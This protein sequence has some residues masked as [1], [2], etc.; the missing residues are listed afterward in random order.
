L[1][2]IQDAAIAYYNAALAVIPLRERDKVPIVRWMVEQQRPQTIQRVHEL[3]PDEHRNIGIL[4]GVCSD[5]L[6]VADFDDL[7]AFKRV[8]ADPAL[9]RLLKTTPTVRTARG[10]H[11][12]LRTPIPVA[13]T[14]LPELKIDVQGQGAYVVAPP[15][16]HPSGQR[17]MFENGFGRIYRLDSLEELPFLRLREAT[18]ERAPWYGIGLRLFGILK[19]E[20]G[21]Y[22]SRSEAEAALV[23]VCARNRWT[24]DE[25]IEL[26]RRHADE[27][28]KYREKGRH[29]EA[30]LRL[31]W[32]NAHRQ[33]AEHINEVDRR[34]DDMLGMVDATLT[35]PR[36]RF[37]DKAVASA[38]LSIARRTGKFENL[39]L[40]V[41]EVA[42][43]AAVSRETV[44]RSFSRIPWLCRVQAATPTK[45]AI[46]SI[47]DIPSHLRIPEG[48]EKR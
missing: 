42:E 10:L 11:I 44:M 19:G 32:E 43:F 37:T 18:F 8:S 36:T 38:V 5:N 39:G 46:Y 7:T 47:C 35:N 33:L 40:S 28:T 41:R 23:L 20:I 13:K 34:I 27:K 48:V 14:R 6:A 24:F 3:F 31:T 1:N 4:C 21:T 9:R 22:I 2:T 26:F 45:P 30:Y 15:S 25:T 12:Y 29:G 16:L 17:Y